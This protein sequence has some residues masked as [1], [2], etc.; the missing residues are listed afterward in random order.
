[1]IIEKDG[2]IAYKFKDD[3]GLEHAFKYITDQEIIHE[4]KLVRQGKQDAQIL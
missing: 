1:M 2:A 4:L 3:L